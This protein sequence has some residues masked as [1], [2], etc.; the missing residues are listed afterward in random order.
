MVNYEFTYSSTKLDS[1]TASV[2]NP[3]V[4]KQQVSAQSQQAQVAV[5]TQPQESA[6]PTPPTSTTT[7]TSSNQ[8][9]FPQSAPHS[10]PPVAAPTQAP[11]IQQQATQTS[12]PLPSVTSFSSHPSVA[13]GLTLHQQQQQLAPQHQHTQPQ[14]SYGHQQQNVHFDGPQLQGPHGT[15]SQN[16]SYFRPEPSFYHTPTPPQ[17]APDHQSSYPAAFSPVGIGAGLHGH[18][19]SLGG[20]NLTHLG[21]FGGI[22][23]SEYGYN[24]G[25]RVSGCFPSLKINFRV[26]AL[27]RTFTIMSRVALVVVLDM[28]SLEKQ[29]CLLD[30]VINPHPF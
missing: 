26:H 28:M 1:E 18:S 23:G 7:H 6:Q 21:G 22:S 13:P 29:D 11:Q 27:S 10:A 3:E 30:K 5:Q 24:D 16:N 15:T 12:Q 8:H 14:H 20:Q 4:P 19:Q 2:L 25:Q 9:I 17:N